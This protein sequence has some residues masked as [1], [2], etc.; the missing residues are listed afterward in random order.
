MEKVSTKSRTEENKL[1]LQLIQ[2]KNGNLQSILQSIKAVLSKPSDIYK[3]FFLFTKKLNK[4]FPVSQSS[5]ILY[6]EQESKLKVIAMKGDKGARKGLKLTLPKEKS[7]LYRVF[8][9]NRFYIQ[10]HPQK[11]DCN[12][13]ENKIFKDDT[14]QSLA[15]LPINQNGAGYGLICLSSPDQ[16][17]FI[18]FE[19]GLMDEILEDFSKNLIKRIPTIKI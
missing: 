6:S 10:H 17:A 9:E 14:A 8:T 12:F 3:L 16:N 18:S 11:C 4:F 13:I 1:D 7:L 2:N 15:I 19:N 5:L